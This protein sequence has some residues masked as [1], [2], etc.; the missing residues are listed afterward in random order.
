M[1][2]EQ[3]VVEDKQQQKQT[4]LGIITIEILI[5]LQEQQL[6]VHRTQEHVRKVAVIA[7]VMKANILLQ[8]E[9]VE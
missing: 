9:I 3:T 6:L 2:Q 8:E 4:L 7:A 1:L 5:I